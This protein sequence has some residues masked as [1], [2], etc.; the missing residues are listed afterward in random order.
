MDCTEAIVGR[1]GR[2]MNNAVRIKIIGATK[3]VKTEVKQSKSIDMTLND[4]NNYT[5]STLGLGRYRQ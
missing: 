2:S 5:N 4:V 3:N 1:M